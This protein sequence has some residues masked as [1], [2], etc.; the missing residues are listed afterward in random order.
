MANR[1]PKRTPKGRTRGKGF[2]VAVLADGVHTSGKQR[3]KS[4]EPKLRLDEGRKPPRRAD[5]TPSGILGAAKRLPG[6]R[7]SD[8][9]PRRPVHQR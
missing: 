1:Q 3:R 9:K 2:V 6:S 7:R 8:G 4:L 5:G